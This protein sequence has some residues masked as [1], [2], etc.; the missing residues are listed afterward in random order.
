MSRVAS[1]W[2]GIAGA[3]CWSVAVVH[4]QPDKLPTPQY[5]PKAKK[6]GYVDSEKNVTIPAT[7]TAALPFSPAEKLAVVKGGAKGEE[8]YWFIDTSGKKKFA[9][10]FDFAGPFREGVARVRKGKRLALLDKDG[11]NLTDFVFEDLGDAHDGLLRARREGTY[12]F[13]ATSG[14]EVFRTRYDLVGDFSYERV[15]F[16]D[17]D[18]FGYLDRDGKIAFE[19]RFEA[20]DTFSSG[21]AVVRQNGA[22]VYI[23]TK[24]KPAFEGKYQLAHPFVGS[25]AVVQ[26]EGKFG[27]IDNKGSVAIKLEYD[28]AEVLTPTTGVVRKGD[29]LM[30]FQRAKG[31]GFLWKMIVTTS[32]V[33]VSINSTPAGA[34]IYKVRS[35]QFESGA[36][37]GT[38]LI[39]RN[40]IGT[41]VMP[42]YNVDKYAVWVFIF[43][44]EDKNDPP[45]RYCD[46]A[47]NPTVRLP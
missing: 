45:Y 37:I 44:Y 26:L 29:K 10:E 41:T 1:R 38:H 31:D 39:P 20:A 17:K 22:Y 23:D 33:P 34:K 8:K 2:V 43:V 35:T 36:P 9:Q 32:D 30:W 11:K 27:V 47:E 46:P 40:Y 15:W 21:L 13:L 7:F 28:Q 19:G 18:G 16:R 24:G 5:D 14:K 25:L 12:S 42:N 6:W 3:L 4:A